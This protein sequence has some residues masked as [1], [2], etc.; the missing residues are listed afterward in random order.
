MSCEDECTTR[1]RV[2]LA[3]LTLKIVAYLICPKS[4]SSGNLS[5]S[6][7]SMLAFTIIQNQY[8]SSHRRIFSALTQNT[9]DVLPLPYLVLHSLVTL[10]ERIFLSLKD[11]TGSRIH[12]IGNSHHRLYRLER[13]ELE[14]EASE[15]WS[16]NFDEIWKELPRKEETKIRWAVQRPASVDSQLHAIAGLT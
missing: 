10:H 15:S 13:Q 5:S 7:A 2:S 9:H 4:S 14:N 12:D 6:L 11:P 1:N 3:F 16:A 8:R